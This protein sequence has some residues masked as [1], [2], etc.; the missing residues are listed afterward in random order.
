MHYLVESV[1]YE[2]DYVHGMMIKKSRL[3]SEHEWNFL[4]TNRSNGHECFFVCAAIRWIREIRGR[5]F[6]NTNCTNEHESKEL[7]VLFL[8]RL[9]FRN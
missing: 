9:S 4:N 1:A 2:I 6:L 3:I 5:F 7:I 8:V